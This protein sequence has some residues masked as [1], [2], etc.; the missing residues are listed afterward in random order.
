ME[1]ESQWLKT[2]SDVAVTV[3]HFVVFVTVFVLWRVSV[4]ELA[5]EQTLDVSLTD[6]ESNNASV[7][8]SAANSDVLPSPD[9]LNS[10]DMIHS[11]LQQSESQAD[12]EPMETPSADFTRTSHLPSQHF[13]VSTSSWQTAAVNVSTVCCFILCEFGPLTNRSVCCLP[14]RLYMGQCQHSLG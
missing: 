9:V 11:W 5:R 12:T 6:T 7:V 8:V 10:L 1:S 3:M 14:H 13:P 4:T 2:V